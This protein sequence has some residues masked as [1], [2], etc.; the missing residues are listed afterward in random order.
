MFKLNKNI[1]KIIVIINMT[2]YTLYQ[3]FFYSCM[4]SK[5]EIKPTFEA[6]FFTYKLPSPKKYYKSMIKLV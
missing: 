2:T 4:K 6:V 5:K 1:L 3:T